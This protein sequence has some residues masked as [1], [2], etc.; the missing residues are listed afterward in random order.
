MYKNKNLIRA[1]A[2]YVCEGSYSYVFL[3]CFIVNTRLTLQHWR[4]ETDVVWHHRTKT[5]QKLLTWTRMRCE[6]FTH[7]DLSLESSK[8]L[9]IFY[10]TPIVQLKYFHRRRFSAEIMWI[11]T[12]KYSGTVYTVASLLLIV[13]RAGYNNAAVA[14]T[15]RCAYIARLCRHSRQKKSPR[16]HVYT[17]NES[18]IHSVRAVAIILRVSERKWP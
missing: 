13:T 12:G 8:W 16:Q 14:I 1:G 3:C 10:D 5:Y 15:P 9:L 7:L 2:K 17:R 11:V 6:F 4:V 18:G